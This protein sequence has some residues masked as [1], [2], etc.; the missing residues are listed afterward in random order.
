MAE[1]KV[2]AVAR[3][4][5]D[6][7]EEDLSSRVSN[8]SLESKREKTAHKIEQGKT[9]SD[10]KEQHGTQHGSQTPEQKRVSEGARS[11]MVPTAPFTPSPEK[12]T[13]DSKP[14]EKKDGEW[15]QGYP[16]WKEKTPDREERMDDTVN[17][18]NVYTVAEKWLKK[19][20]EG[21]LTIEVDLRLIYSQQQQDRRFAKS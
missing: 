18:S 16:P 12:E 14:D 21:N 10:E 11:K 5:E 19:D 1:M 6:N 13:P 9:D 2:N 20:E 4:R 8:F 7:I 3:G 15:L 17:M